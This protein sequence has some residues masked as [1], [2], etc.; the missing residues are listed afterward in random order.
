M[1]EYQRTPAG[2]AKQRRARLKSR[3]GMSLEDYEEML[4]AQGGSCA[5]CP[6]TISQDGRRLAVDHD[7]ATGKVRGILCLRCNNQISLVDRLGI[8][9]LAF[10]LARGEVSRQN[11]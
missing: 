2:M 3:Y 4:A 6:A 1:V 5:L 11:R 8:E 10:Y 7:H 9:A